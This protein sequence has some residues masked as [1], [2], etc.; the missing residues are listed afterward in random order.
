MADDRDKRI[1]ELEAE[2][3]QS[4]AANEA[5]RDELAIVAAERS[6]AVEQRSALAPRGDA[7]GHRGV[8]G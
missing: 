6:E 7:A 5:L 1:E 3:W 8:S 4:Q 2:L